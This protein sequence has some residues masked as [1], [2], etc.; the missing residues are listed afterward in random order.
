MLKVIAMNVLRKT[1]G[2]LQA[3]E[4]FIIM[5]DECADATDQEQ[6]GMIINFT[7]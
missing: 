4:F 2:D 3:T 5:M 1:A 6:V 7:E